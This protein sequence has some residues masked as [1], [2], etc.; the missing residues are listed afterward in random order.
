MDAG[1]QEVRA[2]SMSAS[3]IDAR[4]AQRRPSEEQER[5]HHG[6]RELAHTMACF[7]NTACPESREKTLA[8]AR[9]EEATF[10][11]NAAIARRE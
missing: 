7:I 1:S 6:I 10:W 4:F 3:E 5:R 8:M 2:V 9:L 11:A